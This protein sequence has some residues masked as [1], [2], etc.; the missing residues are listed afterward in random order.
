M[1]KVGE[2]TLE[3]MKRA[4]WY[5]KWLFSTFAKDLGGRILEVGGGIGNFTRLLKIKGEVWSF[6]INKGY[7][8]KLKKIIGDK[9]GFGD[10]ENGKYFFGEKTFTNIICLNVLEHIK[11]D[12][13]ALENMNNLLAKDGKLVL[14]VPAHQPFRGS[15]DEALGHFRR[16]SKKGLSKKLALAGFRIYNLR[17]LNFSGGIGW[18]INSKVLGRKILSEKQLVFFDKMARPLLSLE[19]IIEPP[20]GLSIL[21]VASKK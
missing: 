4:G 17:Y 11:N 8:N 6:D 1:D 19:K 15:L 10:I 9:A 2:V 18:F 5:N 21:A 7:I 13:K 3:I 16:Y 20:F 14:L 12:K